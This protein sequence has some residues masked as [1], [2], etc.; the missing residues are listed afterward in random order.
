MGFLKHKREEIV[1]ELIKQLATKYPTGQTVFITGL[2]A[3][4]VTNAFY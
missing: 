1:H 2:R 4:P 3:S